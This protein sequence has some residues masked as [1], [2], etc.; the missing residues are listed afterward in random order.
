M[1]YATYIPKPFV[2][3]EGNIG[4]GKSTFL[5]LLDNALPFQMIPEPHTRWQHVGDQNL[6][7]LFYKDPQRWA[8]TFQSYAFI[9]RIMEHKEKSMH[10]PH[11]LSVLERSVF[12]DRYCFAKNAYELGYMSEL[13]WSVYQE[14]FSWLITTFNIRPAGFIYLQANPDVCY[15]RIAQR[16][17]HEEGG[18]PLSYIESLHA[19]HERWLVHK[20]GVISHIVDTPV[21][22]IDVN[23]EFV[24]NKQRQA[25]IIDQV[26]QFIATHILPVSAEVKQQQNIYNS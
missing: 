3:I 2:V 26:R 1:S 11:A 14:T 25:D 21:L 17:R 7:D 18:V 16:N 12:S 19:K 9:T 8:Y 20:E 15:H 24:H 23:Q 13:E 6:L 4:V 22:T 10:E 5:S